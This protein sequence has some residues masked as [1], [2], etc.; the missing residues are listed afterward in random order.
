[1]KRF[2]LLEMCPLSDN[3]RPFPPEAWRKLR[4]PLPGAFFF[5]PDVP[6]MPPLPQG[7]AI[8]N[9]QSGDHVNPDA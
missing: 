3:S 5:D 6:Y 8:N 7:D 9:G 4:F 1:M 2:V